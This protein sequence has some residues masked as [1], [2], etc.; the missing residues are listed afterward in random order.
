VLGD[1]LI[2]LEWA[3][4]G[5]IHIKYETAHRGNSKNETNPC[6]QTDGLSEMHSKRAGGLWRYQ[7][8]SRVREIIAQGGKGSQHTG[9]SEV[10][11]D[12]T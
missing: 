2:L 6:R 10:T 4:I 1:A 5:G 7:D 12:V 9:L 3:F 11:T 8:V